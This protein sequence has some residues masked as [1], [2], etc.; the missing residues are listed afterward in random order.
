MTIQQCYA[1]LE[2]DCEEVM[3]RLYSEALVRKFVGK[4]LTDPSFQLLE[5]S[6]Q[7]GRGVPRCPYLKRGQPKS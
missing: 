5:D 7:P 2:G 1:A 4:F 3:G 6:G